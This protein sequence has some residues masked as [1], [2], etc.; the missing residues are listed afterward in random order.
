MKD[1]GTAQS[2][3]V[4]VMDLWRSMKML[5]Q[6]VYVD[7]EYSFLIMVVMFNGFLQLVFQMG[8]M[9]VVSQ[10]GMTMVVVGWEV[11]VLVPKIFNYNKAD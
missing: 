6:F 2:E 10:I 8:M 4:V 5:R 7:D 11:T 3:P 9:V 1:F